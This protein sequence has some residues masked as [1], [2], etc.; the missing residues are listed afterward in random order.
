[1]NELTSRSKNGPG[2]SKHFRQSRGKLCDVS[3]NRG[4]SL[5]E[6]LVSV[7]LLGSSVLIMM[8]LFP[9]AYSS[10]VQARDT[11]AASNLCRQILD[12]ARATPSAALVN[13]T[14]APVNITSDVNGASVVT[15]YF[16]D[17]Q[18]TQSLAVEIYYEAQATVRW[19]SGSVP[20]SG[21]DH[22]LRLNTVI[23]VR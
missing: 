17:L 12:R 11:T 9:T 8:G 18:L 3:R 20:G 14:G 5:L 7:A 16:Y 15:Q 22:V 1:M 23:P 19:N 6:I 10:L 4:L 21:T 13:I 2:Q